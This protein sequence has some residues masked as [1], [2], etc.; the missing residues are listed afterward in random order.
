MTII[1]LQENVTECNTKLKEGCKPLFNLPD[2]IEEK[3]VQYK[4]K[5]SI[6]I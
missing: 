3:K 5:V 2:A 4:H 6:F 1:F